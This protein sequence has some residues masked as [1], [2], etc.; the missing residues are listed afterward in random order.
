MFGNTI[1][2]S[3]EI[4]LFPA[5]DSYRIGGVGGL[6]NPKKVEI[7][8]PTAMSLLG[9]AADATRRVDRNAA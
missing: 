8:F 4:G 6:G 5:Y 7:D 1:S 9:A 2:A 3:P